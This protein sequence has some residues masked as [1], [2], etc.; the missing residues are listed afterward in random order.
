M[1]WKIYARIDVCTITRRASVDTTNMFYHHK[2][3]SLHYLIAML[4][5]SIN[6]SLFQTVDWQKRTIPWPAILFSWGHMERPVYEVASIP[7]IEELR[8]RDMN[9]VEQMS[10]TSKFIG[11]K[12]DCQKKAWIFSFFHLVLKYP[13]PSHLFIIQHPK[14]IKLSARKMYLIF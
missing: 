7:N 10:N 13:F 12:L 1:L 3:Y 6:Q 11:E 8:Q 2:D 9:V 4:E 14:L 5:W